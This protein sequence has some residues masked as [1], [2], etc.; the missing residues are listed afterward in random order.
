MSSAQTQK[1]LLLPEK[2]GELVLTTLPVYEPAKD[3]VLVKVHSTALNPVDWKIQ[4]LGFYSEVLPLVLGADIA[5]EVVGLG[6]GVSQFSKGDKIFFQGVYQEN[7][8]TGFQQFTTADVR[9]LA[10]IPPNISYD[11]AATLPL[12]LSTAYV[13]LYNIKP[14]GMGL[15]TPFKADAGGSYAD[16]PL[17]ILGGSSSV[18][19]LVIQLA[20]LSGFNPIITTSSNKHADFLKSLGATHV[21]DRHAPLS[22]ESIQTITNKPIELVYDAISTEET[23]QAGFNLLASGGQIATVVKPLS[24]IEERGRKEGK[25][26]A[27]VS[28][29]K[30]IPQNAHFLPVLWPHVT[31]LL[32][33]GDLKP[34]RVQ[35]LPNGLHGIVGGLQLLQED[36]VSGVKLVARP[37][38]TV[39][40]QASL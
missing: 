34:N 2:F 30:E 15:K 25:S 37:Q 12:A 31:G 4:K 36:K 18:G 6:E 13:G 17:V 16:V 3:E 5:G 29:K 38:E 33:G 20:K 23:Q 26:V 24:F 14:Y 10:K 8:H 40:P 7:N 21:L 27:W 32:E 1:A 28:A 35:I 11:Q 22:K 19:Q 9:T 39:A